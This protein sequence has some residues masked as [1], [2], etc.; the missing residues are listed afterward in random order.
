MAHSY[1]GWY[2]FSTMIRSRSHASLPSPITAGGPLR[3]ATILLGSSAEITARAKTP[4]S[5]LLSCELPLPKR[6]DAH[7]LS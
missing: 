5:S 7:F 6:Y 4:L 2:L 1:L 3:A